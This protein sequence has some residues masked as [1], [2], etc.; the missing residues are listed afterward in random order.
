MNYSIC[1]DAV[2]AGMD[3]VRA[4]QESARLGFTAVEF[5]SWWDKD[6]PGIRKA[7]QEAGVEIAACCT[8]LVSLTEKGRE[9]GFLQGLQ[10]SV[11]AAK[12][13]GCRRLIAQAG[14]DTGEAAGLQEERIV[15]TLRQAV[16]LLEAGGVTL[17]LEPLNRKID[18]PGCFLTSSEAGFRLVQEVGSPAVRLLFDLYHQQVS[19]GDLLRGLEQN[20]EWIGHFHAAGNP[21]R[22][23]LDRGEINY[24]WIFRRLR[25]MGY[26]GLIGL[27]YHPEEPVE[28]GLQRL[29][30]LG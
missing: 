14:N 10:E 26:S 2:F 15:R 17:L 3:P 21:G 24:P 9:A 8:R 20:L 30:R 25:E 23:E 6:L 18:H 28:R 13:L 11:E 19:E 16:P 1:I 7:V 22:H 12:L 4:I 27:E 29:P 5:W